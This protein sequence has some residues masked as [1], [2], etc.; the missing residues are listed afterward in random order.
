MKKLIILLIVIFS[1]FLI[2]LSIFFYKRNNEICGYKKYETVTLDEFLHSQEAPEN[3][4][5]LSKNSKGD[6]IYNDKVI[7]TEDKKP[8]N[9]K[10]AVDSVFLLKI[11]VIADGAIPKEN[12]DESD[13]ITNGILG[14]YIYED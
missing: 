12:C 8:I 9:D 10:T 5:H 14:C 13:T 7:I 6:V 3:W 1:I 4:K 2:F 11:L